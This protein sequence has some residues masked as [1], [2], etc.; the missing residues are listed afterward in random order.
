M[1]RAGGGWERAGVKRNG[2]SSG[3]QSIIYYVGII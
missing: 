3:L 2:F 1:I